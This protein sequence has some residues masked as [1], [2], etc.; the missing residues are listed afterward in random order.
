MVS[1]LLMAIRFVI[2]DF[3]RPRYVSSK[4]FSG[5]GHLIVPASH[6]CL[7]MGHEISPTARQ[8]CGKFGDSS[9]MELVI[10]D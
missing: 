2:V 5:A 8:E 7:A 3:E 9:G 6:R 1:S 4:H 10:S